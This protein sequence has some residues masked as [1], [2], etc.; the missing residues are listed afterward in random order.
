MEE[1]WCGLGTT[2]ENPFECLK[3]VCVGAKEMAQWVNCFLCNY[4]DLSLDLRHPSKSHLCNPN[5]GSAQRQAA[6]Q[7][8]LASQ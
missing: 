2:C 4:E 3:I 8:L 6:P 7:H 5:S 1:E